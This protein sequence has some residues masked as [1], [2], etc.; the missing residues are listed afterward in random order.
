MLDELARGLPAGFS[1]RARTDA[2]L[3]FLA[4]LYASTRQE[5]LQPVPWTEQEKA[6]F[7]FDQFG[8]QHSHY[9]TYY[10]DALWLVLEHDGEPV[11]RLYISVTPNEFR[12]MDIALMPAFRLRGLGTAMFRSLINQADHHA[13][14]ISLNVEPSNPAR[15]LYLRLG[16]TD[17]ETVGYYQLMHRPANPAI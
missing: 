16:F 17:V 3:A 13:M 7:L 8:K 11:G 2:D 5:E 1:L 14:R 6:A 12:V 4:R 10:P 9:L 15:R